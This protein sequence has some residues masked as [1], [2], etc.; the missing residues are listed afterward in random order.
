MSASALQACIER[1]LK[2]A[3]VVF[4]LDNELGTHH[5]LS[6]ADF[7]LLSVLDVAG[8]AA[9]AVELAH[10]LRVPASHLLIGLLPLE[11]IGMVERRADSDGKRR[12]RLR[13]Q[14]QRL[15]REARITAANACGS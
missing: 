10:S 7:M 13:P 11:K 2:H 15:L 12:I 3:E 1:H 14:G 6:W 5:G 4:K 8:G 9:Q